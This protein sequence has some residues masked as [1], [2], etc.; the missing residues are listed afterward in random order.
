MYKLKQIKKR[1]PSLAAG[2][3]YD[4]AQSVMRKAIPEEICIG[5][6]LVVA[7]I[8]SILDI[9]N[10]KIISGISN[11]IPSP[12]NLWYVTKRACEATFMMIA[13]FV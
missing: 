12:S 4:T 11:C 1:P 10:N 2:I 13:G 9:N 6:G 8:L 7:G 5:G 3:F